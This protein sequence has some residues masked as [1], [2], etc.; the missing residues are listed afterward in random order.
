MAPPSQKSQ[1]R[2]IAI[3]HDTGKGQVFHV[4][5]VVRPEE[6]TSTQ[7]AL[8]T[9][10]QALGG[11]WIDDFGPGLW[12]IDISG[13]TGW[14]A[15]DRPDGMAEFFK[16]HA[17]WN[18]WHHDR[19]VLIREGRNPSEARWFYIDELNEVTALVAPGAFTLKRS[20]N[21]ALLYMYS[22]SMIV[23]SE[24]I[25]PPAV[26]PIKIGEPGATAT[27]K[28]GIDSLS[29]SIKKL[30][31]AQAKLSGI[32]EAKVAGPLKAL[33]GMGTS[34][35]QSV[36][37]AV[38]DARGLVSDTAA[39][40][41]GIASDVALVGRNVFRTFN[42]V[43]NLP[44]F[45]V[46]EVSSIAAAFDNAFCVLKNAFRRVREYP[47]YDGLYGA[48]N[49]SSTIGGSP[50]SAYGDLNAWELILPNRQGIAAV[51]PEA[52][53]Q[54]EVLKGA[55]PVRSP[56]ASDELMSRTSVILAGVVIQ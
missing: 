18:Q 11:A 19:K 3:R 31:A 42:A 40:F 34:S 43:A 26:D 4:P 25:Q 44:D 47:D 50:L 56:M 13:H 7:P 53:T 9:P 41:I 52:R 54:I 38:T 5:L 16:L 14:G 2:A 45:F 8:Q 17:V 49:C 51:T 22:I 15:G 28:A 32:V 24:T 10:N 48:S 35:M 30:K 39:Q 12:K 29:G 20:R 36:V 1:D 33:I 21:R 27:V 23:L 55:D 6:I 46:H 37:D